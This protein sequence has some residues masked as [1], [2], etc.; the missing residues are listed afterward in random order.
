M[1]QR[2]KDDKLSFSKIG[3]TEERDL[4]SFVLAESIKKAVNDPKNPR[5][6]PTDAEILKVIDELVKAN[7]ETIGNLVDNNRSSDTEKYRIE[8][9]FLGNYLPQKMT[10][11]ELVEALKKCFYAYYLGEGQNKTLD[12]NAT[13]RFISVGMK[14]LKENFAGKYDSQVASEIAKNIG[15]YLGEE[16]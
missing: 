3:K 5:K 11:P 10:E 4:L 6:E 8:N 13:K 2:L 1:L 15:N 16:V 12:N 9:E 14:Y 7:C